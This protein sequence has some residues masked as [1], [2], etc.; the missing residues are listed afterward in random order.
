MPRRRSPL[1]AHYSS[2]SLSPYLPGDLEVRSQVLVYSGCCSPRR[3]KIHETFNAMRAVGSESGHQ[4]EITSRER[5]GCLHA[6]LSNFL[7]LPDHDL[8]GSVDPEWRVT[9]Q[10][11]V[12]ASHIRA[13]CCRSA[14][15]KKRLQSNFAFSLRS[16]SCFCIDE[17]IK[18]ICPTQP[19]PIRLR[20]RTKVQKEVK[21]AKE[22]DGKGFGSAKMCPRLT[23]SK[24]LARKT[25]LVL[26][27]W[28]D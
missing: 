4:K 18:T 25:Q 12:S 11:N 5:E 8:W 21:F 2:L 15:K 13:I 23:S 9:Q 7:P 17:E 26:I 22:N 3:L 6:F 28:I 16:R 14:P 20:K 24:R 27:N 10:M 19:K 1:S